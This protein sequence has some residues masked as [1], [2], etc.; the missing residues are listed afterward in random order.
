TERVS[1]ACRHIDPS[2]V[3]GPDRAEGNFVPPGVVLADKSDVARPKLLVQIVAEWVTDLARGHGRSHH[4]GCPIPFCDVVCASCI[5]DERDAGFLA[6]LRDR[7]PF[8]PA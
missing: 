8:M 6:D 5:H 7:R 4:R 2:L 3:M 1:N